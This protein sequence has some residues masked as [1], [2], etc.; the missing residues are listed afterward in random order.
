MP[1]SFTFKRND[2]GIEE[3]LEGPGV[4]A[5]LD[6]LAERVAAEIRSNAP[7][8]FMDYAD[9]IDTE[10]AHRGLSG[11]EAGVVVSSPGWHLPEY[12]SVHTA[13]RAIIANAARSVLDQFEET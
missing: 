12:G 5:H 4:A 13:P 10:P 11:L 6:E 1:G 3:V 8:G 2:R 7:D 9:G